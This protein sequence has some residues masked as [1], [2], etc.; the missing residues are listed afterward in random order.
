MGL[1]LSWQ[2]VTSRG[3]K[4][5]SQGRALPEAGKRG[6]LLAPSFRPSGPRF[7]I[8]SVV[9]RLLENSTW[10]LELPAL[11]LVLFKSEGTDGR[12]G[13]FTSG[14]GIGSATLFRLPWRRTDSLSSSGFVTSYY[15]PGTHTGHRAAANRVR[16]V[17]EGGGTYPVVP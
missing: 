14:R 13:P 4:Q 2:C 7:T 17:L 5:A 1:R 10:T 15:V 8:G 9:G 11:L 16:S 6:H 3:R 12:R